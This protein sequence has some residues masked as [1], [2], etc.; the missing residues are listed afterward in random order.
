MLR[1]RFYIGEVRYKNE[2]FPGPSPRSST[3]NSLRRRRRKLTEQWSHR[4]PN[5]NK[6][7]LCLRGLLFDDAGHRMIPTHATKNGARYRYYVS[8]PYLRGLAKLPPGSISAC[9]PRT[10]KPW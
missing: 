2:I 10:S 4:V 5:R 6:L 7:R 8:Q 9:L 1:N 3:A